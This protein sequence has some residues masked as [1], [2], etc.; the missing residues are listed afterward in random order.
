MKVITLARIRRAAASLEGVMY[1]GADEW[2]RLRAARSLLIAAHP[3]AR[4]A[5]LPPQPTMTVGYR[6]PIYFQGSVYD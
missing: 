6:L 4:A 3:K 1:E 2:D 5:E